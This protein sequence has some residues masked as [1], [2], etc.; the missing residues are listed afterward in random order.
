MSEAPRSFPGFAAHMAALSGSSSTPGKE[1][2]LHG[3]EDYE[4]RAA[5]LE[6]DQGFSREEAERI[7]RAVCLGPGGG[8]PGGGQAFLSRRA[9]SHGNAKP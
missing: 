2:A 6:Y 5:I 4:E 1:P 8:A 7:A 9:P 3:A